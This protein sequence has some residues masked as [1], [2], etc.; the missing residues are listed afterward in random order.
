MFS[1][2]WLK[3]M[4][5]IGQGA[6]ALGFILALGAGAAWLREDA[7]SDNN[8]AWEL[9]LEKQR[10]EMEL[11]HAARAH[12]IIQLERQ[13]IDQDKTL[14]GVRA[15]HAKAIEDQAHSIPLSEACSVCRVPNEHLWLR[16]AKRA[17]S[18]SVK[19]GS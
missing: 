11:A 17:S 18:R 7:I 1:L 6:T 8:Q 19:P 9:K 15:E 10:R 16:D 5:L 2:A 12:R 13:L 14:E 3:D 4:G